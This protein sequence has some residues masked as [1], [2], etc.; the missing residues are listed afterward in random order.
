M[1]LPFWRNRPVS[2]HPQEFG[3]GR[4]F[5]LNHLI[6]ACGVEACIQPNISQPTIRTVSMAT[7]MSSTMLSPIPKTI[8]SK[9]HDRLGDRRVS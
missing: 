2:S 8:S 5:R 4:L 6:R 3:T 9:A 1:T 7:A